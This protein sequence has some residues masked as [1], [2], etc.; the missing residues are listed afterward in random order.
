MPPLFSTEWLVW[1]TNSAVA[2]TMRQQSWLYPSVETLHIL[3]IAILFGSVAMFD[4]RLLG[5]SSHIRVTD[6][7]EHIL[8]WSYAS[9]GVVLLS[10]CLLFVTD[11]PA[12]ALNLAFQWKLVFILGAGVN[13]A[14]FH[15]KF[16][17][18]VQRWNCRVKPPKNVQAIAVVSL[19]L[20]TA[21]IMCGCWIAYV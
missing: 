11:A 1:V 3:G 21:T 20:W 2:E 18:S 7:A 13:A 14:L 15:R 16:Y 5:A 10:G 9:F 4:L 8:G 12:I 19:L 6:M 17:P